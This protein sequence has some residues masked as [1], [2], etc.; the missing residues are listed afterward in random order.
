MDWGVGHGDNSVTTRAEINGLGHY[1]MTLYYMKNVC[2]IY[3]VY[4]PSIMYL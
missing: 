3:C 1:I 4:F 2:G